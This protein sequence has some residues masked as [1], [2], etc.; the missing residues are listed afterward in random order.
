[1]TEVAIQ[2][3][4]TVIQIDAAQSIIGLVVVVLGAGIAWG[5]LKSSVNHIKESLS[6][7][8]PDLKDIRERFFTLEGK[9][10]KLFETAS[11][12]NLSLKGKEVLESSGL[13]KYLDDNKDNLFNSCKSEKEFKTAY[14]VQTA[15]FEFFDAHKFP[16]EV[17]NRLKETAFSIG[18][19]PEVLKRLGAIYFRKF[20]L[21]K[22]NFKEEDLDKPR[23]N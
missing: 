18:S 9:T 7:I 21:E 11:P 8:E 20:C 14:D 13:K 3:T 4:P 16:E 2:N 10:S 5:T 19:S 22:L 1:M 15:V 23:T 17:E 6:K 12:I